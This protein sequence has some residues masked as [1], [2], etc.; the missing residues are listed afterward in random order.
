[1]KL[2]QLMGT[3]LLCALAGS[4]HAQYKVMAYF[5]GKPG[6]PIEPALIAQGRGGYLFT[7]TPDQST[8]LRGVAFKVGTS[9]AVTVLHEFDPATGILPSSGLTLG[10]DGLFYGTTYAGGPNRAGSVF[11][12]TQDGVV[13][14]L[15]EFAGGDEGSPQAALI[16]S[17]HGEFYGTTY[18]DDSHPG[19]VF[20][21]DSFGTYTLLHTFTGQDGANPLAAM[22][23]GTDFWIY[24]TTERGGTND[25]GTLFRVSPA[26][27][28]QHLFD[29]DW[30]GAGPVELIQANDGNFYGITYYGGKYDQG[31][32]YKMTPDHQVTVI[33]DFTGGADGMQPLGG[34]LQASDGNLYGTTV[35]GGTNGFG[36]IF[37]IS[38]SGANFE[39]LHNFKMS[40]GAGGVTMMQHTNGY[41]Y[42]ETGGGGQFNGTVYSGVFFRFNAGLTPFI[43]FLNAYGN[44]G[45]TVQILGEDF[46]SDSQVFFNGVPAQVTQV[47]P[48]FM[49]VVVPSGATTGPIT[50]TTSIG[51]LTSNKAFVVRP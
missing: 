31:V 12:M 21:I 5:N 43:T 46:A 44:V 10:R 22:V 7:T 42:G 3:A 41:L 15:H 27:E 1:M 13:T 4:A 49:K 18:G 23:Q 32:V 20:K 17:L 11:K 24:G 26:G 40:S 16:Q 36:T 47:Q 9:G 8:D 34:L 28:F 2:H 37:R 25:L 35:E 45:E 6:D 14:T 38:T 50:V 48:T 19:A 29:F 33:H 39:V 30:N 51:T